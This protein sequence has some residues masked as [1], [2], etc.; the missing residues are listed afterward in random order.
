MTLVTLPFEFGFG[1][2]VG[3]SLAI[4]DFLPTSEPC[5][6]RRLGCRGRVMGCCESRHDPSL[7]SASRPDGFR[8]G[9]EEGGGS[10]HAVERAAEAIRQAGGGGAVKGKKPAPGGLRDVRLALLA[11]PRDPSSV[12]EIPQIDMAKT[13]DVLRVE[14]E[15]ADMMLTGLVLMRYLAQRPANQKRMAEC[16]CVALVL[17]SLHLHDSNPT[18]QGVACD[19]LGNL[20]QEQANAEQFLRLGGVSAV[21]QVIKAN[22]AHTRVM[23][24]ACFLLGN[25]ASSEDGLQDLAQQE[26]AGVALTVLK[27][28]QHDAELLREILFLV[29]NMA[30]NTRIQRDLVDAGAIDLVVAVMDAHTSSAE[31][32]AMGCSSLDNLI[33]APEGVDAAHAGTR[34]QAL[35]SRAVVE[36]CT[37][38]LQTHATEGSVMRRAAGALATMG[39]VMPRA[40]LLAGNREVVEALVSAG[41]S[42]VSGKGQDT[43]ALVQ[44]LRALEVLADFPQNRALLVNHGPVALSKSISLAPNARPAPVARA[45]SLMAK[46][47]EAEQQRDPAAARVHEEDGLDMVVQS[48]ATFW[49]H[50]AV[51]IPACTIIAAMAKD[52]AKEPGETQPATAQQELWHTALTGLLK[53]LRARPGDVAVAVSACVALAWA[54]ERKLVPEPEEVSDIMGAFVMVMRAHPRDADV[55]EA[56]CFLFASVAKNDTRAIRQQVIKSGAPLLVVMVLRHFRSCPAFCPFLAAHFAAS[57]RSRSLAVHSCCRI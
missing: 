16:N 48:L 46:L 29:S 33:G 43:Q 44:I 42:A 4:S 12:P 53:A 8:G 23:E 35:V 13:V 36:K 47:C 32:I 31:I 56:A 55:A 54:C 38:A 37:L 18:L 26:G 14:A 41:K 52:A 3:N 10:I 21:L 22:M 49:N 34:A 11:L 50:P 7:A 51:V 15:G 24:A 2:K 5:T 9:M 45:L 30:Q 17:R 39:A 40:E 57:G 6:V 27:A 25:V 20:L 28:H 1:Q 19:T